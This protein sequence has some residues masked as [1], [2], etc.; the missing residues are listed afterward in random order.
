MNT[1]FSIILP[2]YNVE[3]YLPRCLDSIVKQNYNNLEII[4]VNDGSTDTS[5]H[6]CD[7]YA[8]KDNRIQ[9]M[10][11]QNAG[12]SAARN[13]GLDLASGDYVSFVDPDD[14]IEADMYQNIESHLSQGD[15]D[16]LRFNA[17]RKGEILNPLPF[18]GK[19]SGKQ[20]QNEVVL[21]FIGASHYGAM[22]ILGVL[23]LHVYKRDIIQK[24][25][26]RFN[27]DLRRCEDRLFTVTA[28]LHANNIFFASDIPY[29]YEVYNDSLS[30]KYDPDRWEQE[31]IYLDCLKKEYTMHKPLDFVQEA[32]RRI[33]YEYLLR[34]TTSINNEFFSEN[35]IGFVKRYFKTKKI[36]KDQLQIIKFREL[37]FDKLSSKQWL[38][39]HLMKHNQPFLLTIIHTIF[40]YKHKINY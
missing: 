4:I 21:P 10:H 38:L 26:I 25:H 28:L 9:V 1:L 20:Y 11:Q 3:Q 13:A 14:W 7:Q 32:N 2:V 34:A 29:H 12:V 31:Q 22:F 37:K 16:I 30:N 23:W 5:G 36:L 17:Y 15:I 35:Q 39:L 40:L 24:H 33:Q 6:I 19:Y 27:T 18:Q 8:L